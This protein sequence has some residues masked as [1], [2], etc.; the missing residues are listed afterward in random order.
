MQFIRKRFQVQGPQRN[1]YIISSIP[2]YQKLSLSQTARN[3][4]K[5]EG[6][7]GLYKGLLPSLLKTAPLSAITF[8]VVEWCNRIFD[9]FL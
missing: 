2:N 8:F 4:V 9:R 7:L 5:Y 6:I 3:I 1:S